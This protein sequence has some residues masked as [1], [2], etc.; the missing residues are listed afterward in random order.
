MYDLLQEKGAGQIKIFGVEWSDFVF[1]RDWTTIYGITRIYGS[2]WWTR[3]DYK[4][5]LTTWFNN[6]IFL[7]NKL[8]NEA[9]AI[10]RRKSNS[11]SPNHI[12]G[13][14]FPDVAAKTL[15]WS[16]RMKIVKHQY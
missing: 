14:E 10:R 11:S 13:R 7:L 1:P 6:L 12:C 3:W 15:N 8:T 2:R 4:E 5:W 16:K 9:G